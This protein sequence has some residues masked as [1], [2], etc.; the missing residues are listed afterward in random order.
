[1]YLYI[2]LRSFSYESNAATILVYIPCLHNYIY[3]MSYGDFS[4]V[5]FQFI[6]IKHDTLL[7]I[8]HTRKPSMAFIFCV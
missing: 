3:I 8:K 6:Y 7:Y 2:L 1:M 5:Y 4:D